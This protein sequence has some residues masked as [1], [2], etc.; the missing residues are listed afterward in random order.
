VARNDGLIA[1][2]DRLSR[3]DAGDADGAR[4]IGSRIRGLIEAI[5][6][7]VGVADEIGSYLA[8]LLSIGDRRLRLWV[9]PRLR[10][11]SRQAVER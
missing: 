2:L 7:P 5:P 10:Q 9:I 11:L 8:G 1:L 6:I 3:V 4:A